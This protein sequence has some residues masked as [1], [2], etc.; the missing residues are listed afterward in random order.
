MDTL[1]RPR[2]RTEGTTAMEV[3]GYAMIVVGYLLF[4]LGAVQIGGLFNVVVGVAAVVIGS[5]LTFARTVDPR[6]EEEAE[7]LRLIRDV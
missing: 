3:A 5:V 1:D 7:F 2:A 6:S 4:A